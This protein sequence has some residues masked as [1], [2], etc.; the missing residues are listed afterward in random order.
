MKAVNFATWPRN[1]KSLLIPVLR[2]ALGADLDL[3]PELI[4]AAEPPAETGGGRYLIEYGNFA[5]ALV[6]RFNAFVAKG[7]EDSAQSFRVF[8]STE[9]AVYKAFL[10]HWVES[11]FAKAQLLVDTERLRKDPGPALVRALE[12]LD[13]GVTLD[14]AALDHAVE[15]AE[16][17]L[18]AHPGPDL[19]K[20][21]F[22]DPALFDQLNRLNLRRDAVQ[23]IFREVMGRELE[24]KS[25][26][27]FQAVASVK[28]LR[29]RLMASPEYRSRQGSENLNGTAVQWSEHTAA[30]ALI[31]L[32]IPKSAG[33][34]LTSILAANFKAGEKFALN[35]PELPAFEA[36]PDAQRGRFRLVFGHLE[37]GV[38]QR[39]P[40]GCIYICALRKPGP[41]LLSYYRYMKRREDHPMY[42]ALNARN[43]SF[44]EFLESCVD[45]YPEQRPEVDNGQIRRLAGRM[46]QNG[47][48]DEHNLFRAAVI[49]AFSPNMVFGLT[50]HLDLL[51]KDLVARKLIRK[52][53]TVVANAAPET[54]N[55]DEVRDGLTDDQR[56]LLDLF[57]VWDDK[58]YDICE[59][60]ILGLNAARTSP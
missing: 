48:G 39:L 23:L 11:D 50:E 51:L 12:A 20:F 40:Q 8:A 58:F 4:T 22:Y 31:H 19:A 44:G 13:P 24:E 16:H 14:G 18:A 55:F 5:A 49:N 35:A 10:H 21:R 59:N 28:K 37:H 25:V 32:H 1:A 7:G 29:A 2:H 15:R 30:P 54:V 36:L 33:T 42:K 27:N 53:Q 56:R 60:Y 46:H 3:Q 9:F 43:M 6:P 17:W 34:S 57:T 38:G 45:D 41:R 26:L 47:I 52:Y